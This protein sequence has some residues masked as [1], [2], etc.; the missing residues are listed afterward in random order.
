MNPSL[1]TLFLLLS[2]GAVDAVLFTPAIPGIAHFFKVTP[3]LAQLSLTLYLFGY[4]LVQLNYGPIANRWGRKKTLYF[5]LGLSA[6]SAFVCVFSGTINSFSLLLIARILMAIGGGVGL[7]LTFTI[8]ADVYP[9]QK[10][11]KVTALAALSFPIL[12]GLATLL[13]GYLV[14]WLGWQSC[15]AFLAFYSVLVLW[16]CTFLPETKSINQVAA[17]HVFKQYAVYFKNWRVVKH[18]LLFGGCSAIAYMYAVAAPFIAVHQLGLH[19]DQYGIYNLW[20]VAAYILGNLLAAGL[21]KLCSVGKAMLIGFTLILLSIVCL[22]LLRGTQTPTAF[23][24]AASL[25]LLGLPSIFTNAT[26]LA[27]QDTPNKAQASAVMSFINMFAAVVALL[28]AESFT[29]VTTIHLV[30]LFAIVWL[31]MAAIF[32]VSR[33]S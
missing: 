8:I 13:G 20:V 10:A 5:G 6:I 21:S 18:G 32:L 1:F 11:R 14:T 22:W 16:L 2:F 17:N 28:I 15:F 23:F 12:P 4:A 31:V 25:A 19:P 27:T 33:E 24:L 26:V 9:E 3:N 30:G 29:G 7:V